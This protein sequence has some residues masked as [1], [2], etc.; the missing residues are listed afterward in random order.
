MISQQMISK[1]SKWFRSLSL[2]PSPLPS[3]ITHK[4][5][6]LPVF[7]CRTSEFL[8]YL[9][10]LDYLHSS[11]TPFL[12]SF[13]TCAHAPSPMKFHVL[14]NT[15]FTTSLSFLFSQ[16]SHSQVVDKHDKARL[17]PAEQQRQQNTLF[18]SLHHSS[19]LAL[20]THLCSQSLTLWQNE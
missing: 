13:H 11:L 19:S 15:P 5:R 20:I 12:D 7:L 9:T 8:Y 18:Q 17:M 16:S 1:T 14:K 4:S 6:P 2:F 3:H 10:A